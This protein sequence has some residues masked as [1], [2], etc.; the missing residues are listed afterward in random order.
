VRYAWPASSPMTLF[1][2]EGLPASSFNSDDT[3]PNQ[4][5]PSK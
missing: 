5:E 1:N 4:Y 3:Y 2:R